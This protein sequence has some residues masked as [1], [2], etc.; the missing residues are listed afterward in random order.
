MTGNHLAIN[1]GHRSPDPQGGR[2]DGHT[3][4]SAT[5]KARRRGNPITQALTV[6][7]PPI[8]STLSDNIV[9]P[10]LCRLSKHGSGAER[11]VADVSQM[12]GEVSLWRTCHGSH[13]ILLL[14][15]RQSWQVRWTHGIFWHSWP[16]PRSLGSQDPSLD[17]EGAKGRPP[18]R[19]CCPLVWVK[20]V[21]P[22]MSQPELELEAEPEDPIHTGLELTNIKDRNEVEIICEYDPTRIDEEERVQLVAAARKSNSYAWMDNISSA[23]EGTMTRCRRPPSSVDSICT[24]LEAENVVKRHL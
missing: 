20:A 17:E 18:R 15:W 12:L 22:I 11:H 10:E 5:K 7:S 16:Q 9:T 23:E 19:P 21:V 6:S 3:A 1:G 2:S 24:N 4:S 14:R 8:F 13:R